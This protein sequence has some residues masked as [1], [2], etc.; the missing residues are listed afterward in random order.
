M[1]STKDK[2]KYR[3]YKIPPELIEEIEK[4]REGHEEYR[5]INL[6]STLAMLL[7]KGMKEES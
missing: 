6:S 1:E 7:C 3:D 4:F 5:Y 2:K